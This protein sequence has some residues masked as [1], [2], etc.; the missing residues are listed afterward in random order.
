MIKL[1]Q[2]GGRLCGKWCNEI[3]SSNAASKAIN[4]NN[5]SQQHRKKRYGMFF[6][7]VHVT[8]T[9]AAS[10]D[11]ETP[12]HIQYIEIGAV[13]AMAVDVTANSLLQQVTITKTFI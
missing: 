13:C 9:L 1:N 4:Q 2:V 11:T 10:A 7:M 5:A 12:T 6:S 8:D 3:L